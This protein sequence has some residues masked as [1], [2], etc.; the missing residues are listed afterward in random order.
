MNSSAIWQACIDTLS[1]HD[2]ADIENVGVIPPDLK[3]AIPTLHFCPEW[4][5]MLLHAPMP[6]MEMCHCDLPTRG[7]S[8]D[9]HEN[10]K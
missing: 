7:K 10:H 6:E 4:D 8:H 2:Y 9:R 5:C 1:E 3:A